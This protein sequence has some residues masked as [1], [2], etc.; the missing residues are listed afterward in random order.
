MRSQG[1]PFSTIVLAVISILILVLVVFFVTG[2]FSKLFPITQRYTVTSIEAARAECLKLLSQA[3][4]TTQ[5]SENP[6]E[7][8]KDTEYCKA[9]FNITGYKDLQACYSPSIGITADFD[10]VTSSG[11]RYHCYA[12]GSDCTCEEYIG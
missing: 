1:L 2:G 5:I 7:T 10:V 11:K 4:M 3:Q 8:F 12:R 6:T 9:K